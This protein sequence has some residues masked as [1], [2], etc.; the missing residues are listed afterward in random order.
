MLVL[1]N[2]TG[3]FNVHISSRSE[4]K[5]ERIIYKIIQIKIP[6]TGSKHEGCTLIS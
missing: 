6:P 5:V 2:L 3:A 4:S 1:V